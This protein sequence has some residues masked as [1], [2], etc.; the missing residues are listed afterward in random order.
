VLIHGQSPFE[1]DKQLES[2]QLQLYTGSPEGG[3]GLT[4]AAV[5]ANAGGFTA[6]G[7]EFGVH[8]QLADKGFEEGLVT[9]QS[10]GPCV[11]FVPLWSLAAG[12]SFS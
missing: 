12:A 7:R 4:A 2:G 3:Q 8:E 11:V 9:V 5:T 6:D 1:H 10:A